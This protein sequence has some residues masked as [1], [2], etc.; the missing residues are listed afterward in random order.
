MKTEQ[1]W[2][3]QFAWVQS[4]LACICKVF[5]ALLHLWTSCG[6]GNGNPLQYSCLEI[7]TDR[8]AW[9]VTVH[10][11]WKTRTWLKQH[12]HWPRTWALPNVQQIPVKWMSHQWWWSKPRAGGL[13]S[14][15]SSCGIL[16][17]SPTLLTQF[18]LSTG[19]GRET[20]TL[21]AFRL[22]LE[23]VLD[24]F[25]QLLVLLCTFSQACQVIVIKE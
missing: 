15:R 2:W 16:L 21:C 20:P 12:T 25:R 17:C 11:L 19:S 22:I 24:S 1:S 23:K 14:I 6:E 4:S 7:P 18:N 3:K 5:H 9:Q 13:S 8:G 10:G